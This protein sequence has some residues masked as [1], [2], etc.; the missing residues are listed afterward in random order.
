MRVF[1]HPLLTLALRSCPSSPIKG[2][3]LPTFRAVRRRDG[4]AAFGVRRYSAALGG[5]AWALG[6]DIPSAAIAGA[7]QISD[8]WVMQSIKGEGND[9]PSSRILIDPI[10]YNVYNE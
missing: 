4:T 9:L 5:V 8:L 7:L 2:F 3:A 1:R 10:H 6:H